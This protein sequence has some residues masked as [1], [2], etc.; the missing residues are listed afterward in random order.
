MGEAVR[1]GLFALVA[2]LLSACANSPLPATGAEAAA[3]ASVPEYQ[4]G[5]GD[6]LRIIV[7]G[8]E[9]LS[10][11]YAVNANGSVAFPLIGD[12]PARGLTGRQLASALE[13]QLRKGYLKNPQVSVEVL[14]YRPYYILGEVNA[15]G[16]YPYS[17]GLTVV[18]AV[19]TAKGFSYRADQRRVFIRKA[20]ETVERETPLTAATPVLPGDTVRIGERLF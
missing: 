14:T 1:W 15:P 20:G 5:S 10:K 18:N 4:L 2:L 11:E 8:E 19:A 12:V 6:K 9:E 3:S 7:F 17:N 16:E 13:A